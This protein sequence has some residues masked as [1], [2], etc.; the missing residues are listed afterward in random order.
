[1]R[2]SRFGETGN[3]AGRDL[4]SCMGAGTNSV[5]GIS[6]SFVDRA[7]GIFGR[8]GT[9][10]DRDGETFSLGGR[11]PANCKEVCSML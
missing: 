2:C 5:A 11:A 8:E 1:M 10:A 3:G 9:G 7:D 6:P 4:S